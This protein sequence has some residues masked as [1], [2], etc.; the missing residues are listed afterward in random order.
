M[1]S[2]T[3]GFAG[4]RPEA[5]QFLRELAANNNRDWF[6]A[7]KP[8]YERDVVAPFR[9][10]LADAISALTAAGSPL[11]GDPAKAIFRIHRDVRFSKDKLPYKTNSGAVLRRAGG[12]KFDGI[13]YIHVDPAGCFLAAGFY[14]PEKEALEAIREAIYVDPARAA[15]LRADLAGTKLGFDMSETLSRMPR[16]F[17]DAVDSPIADLLRLKSFTVRRALTLADMGKPA[18]VQRVL[19]FAEDS[20]ALLNF[21]W[22]A[23]TVLDPTALTR[24]R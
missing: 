12:A 13:L 1:A 3:L 4:F 21:G 2:N 14:L 8:L 17:E 10:L 5:F 7:N 20:A 22:Q 6:L 19:E 16:G 15:F 9:L 11:T 23:L 18:L 24:R